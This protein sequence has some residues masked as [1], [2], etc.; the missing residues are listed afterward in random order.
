[1]NLDIEALPDDSLLPR[2]TRRSL[3]ISLLRARDAV[4]AR[5]RPILAA[6]DVSE[7][8]WRV[9]RVLA[10]AGPLDATEVAERACLLAPSLTRIMRSLEERRFITRDRDTGDGRR[11][12]LAISAAGIAFINEVAPASKQLYSEIE[13]RFGK[14]RIDKLL[15]MLNELA[16]LKL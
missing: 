5:F 7:Q 9:L 6:R 13:A 12:R 3:P 10:E 11:V 8:Q 2:D 15:D 4:M 14:E 16:I 1:M